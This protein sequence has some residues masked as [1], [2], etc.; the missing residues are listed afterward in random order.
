V[1]S[2]L[3]RQLNKGCRAFLE[4]SSDPMLQQIVVIDAPSVLDWRVY[5]EV[6]ATMPGSGLTLLKECLTELIKAKIIRP[7]P[8]DALAHLLSGAMDEAALWIAQSPNS[9]K[10]QKEAQSTLEILLTSL[11][12]NA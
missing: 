1:E 4:A 11:R 12:L 3:W 2:D 5:R 9:K 7:L 8:V 6:D 10:A